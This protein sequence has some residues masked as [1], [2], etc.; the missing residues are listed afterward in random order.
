MCFLCPV[1][2]HSLKS[3]MD[4]RATP[5]LPPSLPNPCV[6]RRVHIRPTRSGCRASSRRGPRLH[7][8]SSSSLTTAQSTVLLAPPSGHSTRTPSR[9]PRRLLAAVR[10]PRQSSVHVRRGHTL[11]RGG[12]GGRGRERGRKGNFIQ[13]RHRST[14]MYSNAE[15]CICCNLFL[16]FLLLLSLLFLF[17]L[18]LLLLLPHHQRL[19]GP[20]AWNKH[21]QEMKAERERFKR[22]RL[23]LMNTAGVSMLGYKSLPRCALCVRVCSLHVISMLI[24]RMSVGCEMPV[25]HR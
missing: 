8:L 19:L 5:S 12:G 10:R 14:L 20:C 3:R 16:L 9:P 25:P 13:N 23:Q 17:F 15:R 1:L 6:P 18:L 7:L 2:C 11:N 21:A 24:Y 22:D 4:E